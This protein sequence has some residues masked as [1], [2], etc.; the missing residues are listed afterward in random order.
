MRTSRKLLLVLLAGL[1]AGAP[2]AAQ[3][4]LDMP[5]KTAMPSG[6]EK[7]MAMRYPQPVRVGFL[8]GLPVLDDDNGTLGYVRAVVRDPQGKIKLIVIYSRWWGWFGRSVA[9]PLEVVGIFGRQLASL[10]MK[11]AEYAMAP[12]WMV[13]DEQPIAPDEMIRIALA[14]R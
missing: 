5:P 6:A 14:R 3:A 8:I 7:R 12:T 9:V 2:V 11:P 1:L 13:G 10:D 4:P